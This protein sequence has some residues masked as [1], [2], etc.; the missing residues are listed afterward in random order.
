VFVVV[1]A[2]VLVIVVV[3]FVL[4]V[5]VFV[6]V[7]VVVVTAIFW[8]YLFELTIRNTNGP[9]EDEIVVVD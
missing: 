8:Y 7:V 4:V 5:A 9:E 6:F 1:V 2:F 3:G